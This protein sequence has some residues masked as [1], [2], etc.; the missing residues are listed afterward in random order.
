M[1]G[2][3]ASPPSSTFVDELPPGVFGFKKIP[4]KEKDR[5][6]VGTLRALRRESIAGEL[7]RQGRPRGI[8]TPAPTGG[9]PSVFKLPLVAELDDLRGAKTAHL[10]QCMAGSRFRGPMAIKGARPRV[11]GAA[12]ER[13]RE[14][15]S[16]ILEGGV[17]RRDGIA[18]DGGEDETGAVKAMERTTERAA[19]LRGDSA[20]AK[21]LC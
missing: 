7:S 5:V 21:E 16:T 19:R 10:A 11:D 1:M 2:P 20:D 18:R 15:H 6:R 14:L 4:G 3:P 9:A 17:V 8:L 13:P 12:A